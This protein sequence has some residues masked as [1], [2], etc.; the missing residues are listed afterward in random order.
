MGVGHQMMVLACGGLVEKMPKG[1]RGSNQPVR[2]CGTDK[3]MVTMQNHG[4]DVAQGS[5]HEDVARIMLTN[6]ND[7]SIEGLYY[8]AFPGLSIQ[9]TPNDTSPNSE[10]A[11]VY[12]EFIRLMKEGKSNE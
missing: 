10:T 8:T 9:F 4:Y 7:N 12:D 6:V 2:I 5:L 11:W 3:V 1:H